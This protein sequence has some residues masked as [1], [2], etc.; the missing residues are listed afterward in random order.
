MLLGVGAAALIS[1]RSPA[2]RS[3]PARSSGSPWKLGMESVRVLLT[4][5]ALASGFGALVG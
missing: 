5:V 4:G 3:R 1:P 2:P